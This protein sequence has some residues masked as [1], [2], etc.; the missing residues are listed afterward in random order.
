MGKVTLDHPR[1]ATRPLGPVTVSA[2]TA[3][4]YQLTIII[5]LPGSFLT[6]MPRRK[7]QADASKGSAKKLTQ[8]ED[9]GFQG[10][11]GNTSSDVG[12]IKFETEIVEVSSDSEAKSPRRPGAKKRKLRHAKATADS[13]SAPD[14]ERDSENELYINNSHSKGKK[15]KGKMV[16]SDLEEEQPRRRKLVKGVRPPS[17]Q[18]DDLMDEVDEDKIINERLRTRNKKSTFMKNLDKLRKK[19]RGQ[20]LSESESSQDSDGED[21]D[22]PPFQ[23]FAGSKPHID[24]DEAPSDELEG[25]DND[26]LP[27]ADE[28]SWIVQDDSITSAPELPMAF[29]MNTHQDLA[30]HFKII[31]QF[32]LHLAVQRPKKRHAF[33][34]QSL[35]ENEYFSVPLQVARRKLEG[36]R[37]SLVASS[38]WR[39]DFKRPL[40]KYPIFELIRL[41][42]TVP[43]CDAC[44]LGGRL[45]TFVGRL[46]GEPYDALGFERIAESDSDDSED[47]EATPKKREF[48]L[49]RFCAKRTRSFHE[50]CHWEFALHQSLLKEVEELKATKGKRGFI[51]VAFSGSGGKKPPQDL[52][53]ADAIMDW[54]DQRGIINM[55][56]HKI[57]EMMERAR[58]L[59]M[60]AKKGDDDED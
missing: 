54:L 11:E 24:S 19:K 14:L 45:S 4:Q 3:L 29:S 35:A 41:D 20:V 42:F 43:N 5:L 31:C 49:G 32:F 48:D 36:M 23:P 15:G 25:D 53:D 46:S 59:E 38:V 47:E 57:K 39:P 56:W 26:E 17:P 16:Y 52:K 60:A 50:F 58:N 21:E 37:D 51:R 2:S 22:D 8:S 27:A 6:S 13:E 44:H 10:S 1:D 28:D 30:H 12:A 18:D 9:D 7:A 34:K 33:M 40:Q 55:E